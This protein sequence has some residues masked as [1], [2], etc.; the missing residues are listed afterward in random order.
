MAVRVQV[1][2]E[3]RRAGGWAQRLSHDSCG[4]ARLMNMQCYAGL[5]MS[6]LP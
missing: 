2:P 1:V 4:T 3:N 5:L 6:S